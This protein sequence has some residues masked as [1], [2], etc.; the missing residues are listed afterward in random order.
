[1]TEARTR[2]QRLARQEH[3]DG[4]PET[5]VWYRSAHSRGG[6]AS[7]YHAD[8]ECYQILDPEKYTADTRRAAKLRWLAPC[9]VC[10]LKSVPGKDLGGEPS[11]D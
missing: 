9:Q 10:V 2:E 3:D 4:D 8:P 7:V 1:M 11:D 6:R 5:E